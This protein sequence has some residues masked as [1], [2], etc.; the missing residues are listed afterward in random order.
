MTR[1]LYV[2][3]LRSEGDYGRRKLL[4]EGWREHSS[5]ARAWYFCRDVRLDARGNE[6][7]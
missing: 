6:K 4:A 5:D 7:R 2:C 1:R 3:V